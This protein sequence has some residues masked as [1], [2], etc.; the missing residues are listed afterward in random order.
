MKIL[1]G[2]LNAEIGREDFFKL[3]LGVRVVNFDTSKNLIVRSTVLPH[4]NIHKHTWTSPD[5]KIRST[6]F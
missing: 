3:T 2:D 4:H 6:I 5:G 1:L